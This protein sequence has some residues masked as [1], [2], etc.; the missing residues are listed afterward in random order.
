MVIYTH[1]GIIRQNSKLLRTMLDTHRPSSS[2]ELHLDAAVF[3]PDEVQQALTYFC[4]I[5]NPP[6]SSVKEMTPL[7]VFRLLVVA[8]RLQA[9]ELTGVCAG[10]FKQTRIVELDEEPAIEAGELCPSLIVK[11]MNYVYNYVPEVVPHTHKTF[12][13]MLHDIYGTMTVALQQPFLGTISM[14]LPFEVLEA[15]LL[16][17]RSSMCPESVVIVLSIWRKV[18][19]T[20]EDD[21]PR[22]RRL[23]A[24]VQYMRVFPQFMECVVAAQPW[25]AT[26]FRSRTDVIRCMVEYRNASPIE[27][28]E[29]LRWTFTSDEIEELI[30]GENRTLKAL[31]RSSVIRGC[32]WT[33]VVEVVERSSSSEGFVLTFKLVPAWHYSVESRD[34][35]A[36]EISVQMMVAMEAWIGNNRYCFRRKLRTIDATTLFTSTVLHR[37][38]LRGHFENRFFTFEIW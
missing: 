15:C 2:K 4:T 19:P 11:L 31:N 7:Q 35:K 32:I 18:H 27:P 29:K 38:S 33:P 12:V 6:Q 1:S 8:V 16:E 34:V 22:L 21:D 37:S 28:I 10:V 3:P 30:D 20:L 13:R 5:R 23:A 14:M 25:L 36:L 24:C 17:Y 9:E 26:Y